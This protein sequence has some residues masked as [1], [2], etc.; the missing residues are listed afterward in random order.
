MW[1]L[2]W[3]PL[4]LLGRFG[5]AVGSLLFM[6]LKS[7]RHIALTNLRLCMPEL[8]EA[9]RVALARRHFQAYSRSVWER[10]I[11]WWAP[12]SRLRRLI[13]VEPAMPMHGPGL[14]HRAGPAGRFRLGIVGR[15]AAEHPQRLPGQG[16]GRG[17]P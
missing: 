2:H 6:L 17:Q 13:K 14:Q 16:L 10:A 12:E 9:E 4:P 15:R 7:R 3:L 5:E 11:L 8:S 1:L